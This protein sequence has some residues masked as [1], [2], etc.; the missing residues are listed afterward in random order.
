MKINT[1]PPRLMKWYMDTFGFNA[2]AM[3]Y[4]EV[5]YFRTP[6]D[7]TERVIK[8]EKMHFVQMERDGTIWFLIKYVWYILR[9]GYKNNPYEEESRRAEEE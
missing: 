1:N 9:Y 3:P 7:M 8:H 5:M 6:E 2:I 4:T